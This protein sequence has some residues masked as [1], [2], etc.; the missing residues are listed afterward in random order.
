MERAFF[1]MMIS[2][3]KAQLAVCELKAD[4]ITKSF[5][6]EL[7]SVKRTKLAF[8]WHELTKHCDGLR[9]LITEVEIAAQDTD[10]APSGEPQRAI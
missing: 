9:Q 3:L 10:P 4:S 2:D 5:E 6:S 8:A 1:N 7:S